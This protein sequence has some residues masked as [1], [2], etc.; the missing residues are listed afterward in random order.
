VKIYIRLVYG[1]YKIYPADERAED[2]AELL[3]VRTF[4]NR[5]LALIERLGDRIET[6]EDAELRAQS[7]LDYAGEVAAARRS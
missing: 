4:N 1:N 6:V 3:G 2:F 7:R 5:Q